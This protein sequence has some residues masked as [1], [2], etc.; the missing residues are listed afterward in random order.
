MFCCIWELSIKSFL[1]NQ[2]KQEKIKIYVNLQFMSIK[3]C[4]FSAMF[5]YLEPEENIDLAKMLRSPLYEP[6]CSR[7]CYVY[8]SRKT[9][10]G[11][12]WCSTQCVLSD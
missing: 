3:S 9:E 4:L 6:A 5:T 2:E 8:Q 7:S 12:W 1:K 11:N 10:E